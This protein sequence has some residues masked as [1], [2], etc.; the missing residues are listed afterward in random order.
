[1]ENITN[2]RVHSLDFY[3][4]ESM[5]TWLLNE[6]KEEWKKEAYLV[7]GLAAEA[8]EILDKYAK[9]I[10]DGVPDM[11]VA[12]NGMAKELGDVLWFVSVLA[13]Y[14]GYTLEEIANMN[15]DKLRK[16]QSQ[17]TLQGAGDDR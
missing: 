13:H 1:M 9:G 2:S 8:G 15:I 7:S 5:K 4:Q 16:R 17:N 3:Q 11:E 10:R 6:N 14:Y 12:L